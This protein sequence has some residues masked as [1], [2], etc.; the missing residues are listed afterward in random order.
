MVGDSRLDI[1]AGNRVGCRTYLVGDADER[2][3]IIA[4]PGLRID[5]QAD[6]LLGI[7]RGALRL[8]DLVAE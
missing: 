3:D 6:T 2:S 8:G 7:V 1:E 5:G 4:T